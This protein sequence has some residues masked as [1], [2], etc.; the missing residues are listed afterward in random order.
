M[1]VDARHGLRDLP[2]LARRFFWS[3]RA[4]APDHDTEAWLVALLN[5]AEA[6]LYRAQPQVDRSHS[7]SCAV[8]ARDGLG[9]RASDQLVVASAMHDVGKAR[10]QLGTIGRV[11][12]T[13]V[14]AVVPAPTMASWAARPQGWRA[15]FGWYAHHDRYGAELLAEAGSAAEVVA[16]AA[17]HHRPES[18]WS[19]DPAIGR[20]LAAADA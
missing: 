9:T 17:E 15:R 20:V 3:L 7:V 12:A 4:P 2:H 6:E 1:T 14:S 13:V 16:W 11:I 18:E 8:A 10:A 19:L 5:E